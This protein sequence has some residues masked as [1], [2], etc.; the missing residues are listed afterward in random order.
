MK[1]ILTFLI[2]FITSI[3]YSQS[4]PIE[5]KTYCLGNSSHDILNHLSHDATKELKN[6]IESNNIDTIYVQKVKYEE[7]FTKYT[8]KSYLNGNPYIYRLWEK[9]NNTVKIYESDKNKKLS[10]SNLDK[11]IVLYSTDK[12]RIESLSMY[13]IK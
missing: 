11:L 4:S 13:L 12:N 5:L 2:L 7:V 1:S 9:K 8:T 6:F 3:T 10:E